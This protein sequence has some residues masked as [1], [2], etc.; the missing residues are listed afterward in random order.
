MENPQSL[1]KRTKILN[2]SYLLYLCT[3]IIWKQ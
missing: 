3:P 2:Y 1:K